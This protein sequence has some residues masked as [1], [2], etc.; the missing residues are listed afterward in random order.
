[1]EQVRD[2]VVRA[3]AAPDRQQRV[4]AYA[5]LVQRFRD[6]ACGY[7]YSILGDF[8]L[9]EDAAQEAFVTAFEKLSQLKQPEAFP[10]WLRRIVW[11]ACRRMT[12][13]REIPTRP[14]EAATD[15]RSEVK[16]PHTLAEARETRD[17]VLE[18]VRRLPARQR[19]VTALFYING[20][21]QN[22]IAAFL[23]V[24]VSRV[25]NR[26][27]ASRRRLREGMLNMLAETFHSNAPDERFDKKVV[28]ELLARPRAAGN[29]G[30][31]PPTDM[32]RFPVPL[33]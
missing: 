7:A 1:M 19:E 18:A 10:G 31:S 24:P 8:H 12:R 27:S 6:M 25:K 20:Y 11:T 22:E 14:L 33:P 32:G 3:S 15:V 16:E 4:D 2:L 30:S 23:D 29:R 26:L 9:A 17:Q 28:E 21:S 13:K 5:R